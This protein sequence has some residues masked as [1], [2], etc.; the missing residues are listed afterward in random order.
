MVLKTERSR[1]NNIDAPGWNPILT[2]VNEVAMNSC[3]ACGGSL[4]ERPLIQHVSI[5]LFRCG[6]CGS[7][8]ALPRPSRDAQSAL[9]DSAAYFHHPYFENRR[10]RVNAVERRCRAVFAKLAKAIDIRLLRGEPHLDVGCDTAAFLLAASRFYG[11]LPIG[12]DIAAKSIEEASRRGVEAHR[13]TL[14]DAPEHLRAIAL[15]T[16]I[17]LLEHVVDPRLFLLET[18]RRLRPGGF[19]YFETP[20]IAS[21]VYRMGQALAVATRGRPAAMLER[22]FPPEHIQYFSRAGLSNLATSA[23]LELVS[24]ETRSLPFADLA[25]SLPL[26][27][28]ICAM[29]TSDAATGEAILLCLLCRRSL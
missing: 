9:H 4:G 25:I 19:A 22:L 20:N 12:I 8:T 10:L 15:L 21:Q 23:G 2:K 6:A 29:Q 11:T 13:C 5:K 14:E 24:V 17:D 1:R 26:R 16:A 28:A 7:A 18:R 27:F 3:V